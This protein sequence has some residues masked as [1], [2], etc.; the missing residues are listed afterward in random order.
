MITKG[1]W[2]YALLLGLLWV[3]AAILTL[4]F[5]PF[6]APSWFSWVIIAFSIIMLGTGLLAS[7]GMNKMLGSWPKYSAEKGLSAYDIEERVFQYGVLLIVVS[8][9]YFLKG[10]S[11]GILGD[12]GMLIGC[13]LIVCLAFWSSKMTGQWPYNKKN[14]IK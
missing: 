5:V 2:K 13:I 3:I 12:I 6:D 8:Y 14:D 7:L 11:T 4:H 10:V 9:F 1:R